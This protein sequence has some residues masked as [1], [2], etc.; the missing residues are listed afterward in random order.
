MPSLFGRIRKTLKSAVK[1]V[2]S[3]FTRKSASPKGLQP[4]ISVEEYIKPMSPKAPSPKAPSPKAP[5]PKAPSP[6]TSAKAKSNA[7]NAAARELRLQKAA[8]PSPNYPL[9]HRQRATRNTSLSNALK[10]KLRAKINAQR[11]SRR[12]QT[13][14]RYVANNITMEN[15]AR[16]L[17]NL[18]SLQHRP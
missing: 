11:R 10:K 15:L 18:T 4:I 13:S 14:R 8:L 5:S 7:I 6:K 17:E 12:S 3:A 2:R 16:E 9:L 1:R